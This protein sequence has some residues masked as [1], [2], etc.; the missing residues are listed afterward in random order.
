LGK[1]PLTFV[2]EICANIPDE[3]FNSVINY[4]IGTETEGDIY[5]RSS[6]GTMLPFSIG[7]SYFAQNPFGEID[8]PLCHD[9]VKSWK[10]ISSGAVK[11]PQVCLISSPVIARSPPMEVM[12][13]VLQGLGIGQLGIEEVTQN[14]PRWANTS[15]WIDLHKWVRKQLYEVY[16]IVIQ[17]TLFHPHHG[18]QFSGIIARMTGGN[19]LSKM[20]NFWVVFD[21]NLELPVTSAVDWTV[22]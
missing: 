11:I 14:L 2:D 1:Y 15:G 13:T 9:S 22:L 12:A 18:S 10:V 16:F 6:I 7:V 17:F 21:R 4:N 8:L 19:V 3:F 5:A 20:G